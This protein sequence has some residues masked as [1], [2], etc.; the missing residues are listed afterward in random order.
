ML[1][2]FVNIFELDT[3]DTLLLLLVSCDT[4]PAPESRLP[5]VRALRGWREGRGNFYCYGLGR[6]GGLLTLF[7]KV[8]SQNLSFLSDKKLPEARPKPICLFHF[9]VK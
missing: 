9:G 2:L 6:R 3:Q 5:G 7:A 8:I 4:L 1:P